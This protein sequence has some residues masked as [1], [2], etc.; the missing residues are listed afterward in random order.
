MQY[1]TESGGCKA[2]MKIKVLKILQDEPDIISGEELSKRLDV[3]RVTIWKHIKSLQDLGYQVTSGP[4]GYQLS[5]NN[6]FL[7]SWEFGKRAP[8]IHYHKVLPSTMMKAREIAR[9]GVPDQ[10]VVVC[11]AQQKGRGRMQRKW[12]SKKGGLY[13]TL[14]LRPQIPVVTGFLVNFV[15]SVALVEA[16]REMTGLDAKVKWPN[17]ILLGSKK[18]SGMLSEMEAEEEMVSFINIGIGINVNNDPRKE[19]HAATSIAVELGRTISRRELLTLFLDKLET[20]QANLDLTSAV[21]EWKK[22]TMTIGKKVKIV[23]LKGQT[24][25]TALDVDE[26]GALI[27]Q[28]QD[29]TIEKV[30][31]GD[32]FHI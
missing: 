10:S 31:Y 20:R 16:I 7:Y 29:G 3:S 12:V 4:K 21:T 6:D 5:G 13:F 18:L 2:L 19:E 28:L 15:T 1:E 25:G 30:I 26:T 22:Y 24:E 8:Q 9:E 23:T 14:V 17:D 11:E 32:C 27:L